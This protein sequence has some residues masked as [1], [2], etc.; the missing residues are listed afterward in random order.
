VEKLV[1]WLSRQSAWGS[2]TIILGGIAAF[3][4]LT[5][6][7]AV[8]A[9]P[10]WAQAFYRV[11]A[12]LFAWEFWQRLKRGPRVTARYTGAGVAFFL[13]GALI[14]QPEVL[15]R[16]AWYPSRTVALVALVAVVGAA[17]VA[18]ITSRSSRRVAVPGWTWALVG[19]FITS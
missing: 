13:A 7:V 12:V 8:F 11:M 3:V 5:T 6:A 19:M 15:S 9:P 10:S 16:L 17:G 4:V 14:R 1:R 18:L 2:L